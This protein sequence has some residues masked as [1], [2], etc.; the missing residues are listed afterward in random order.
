MKTN[1]K[2]TK[3]NDMNCNIFYNYNTFDTHRVSVTT[4]GV[5]TTV[6]VIWLTE[7]VVSGTE[8]VDGM[9]LLTT[10]T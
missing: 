4:A 10:F 3:F 1:K 2:K 8:A 9:L 5:A 6:D 7:F